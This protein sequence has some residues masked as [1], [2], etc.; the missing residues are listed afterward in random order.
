VRLGSAPK[1][2]R[3]TSQQSRT[4]TYEISQYDFLLAGEYA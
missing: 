1:V 3:M 2:L 4:Q